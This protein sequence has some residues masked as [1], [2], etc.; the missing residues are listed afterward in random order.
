[1]IRDSNRR[2][3][4]LPW[5]VLLALAAT[6]ATQANGDSPAALPEPPEHPEALGAGVGRAMHLLSSSTAEHRNKVRILFYGQSI[7]EQEWWRQVVANLRQRFPHADLEV[8]NRAIGGFPSQQLVKPAEH[9]I[10]AFYPDLVI[11]HV[12]GSDKTYAEII[13]SIRSRTTAEVLMQTDHITKWPPATISKSQDGGA[14]WDDRMNRKIL[15]GIAAKYGCGLVDIHSDWLQHL[16]TNHLEPAAL[17]LDEVHLNAAGCDLMARLVE[18]YLV[19]QLGPSDASWARPVRTEPI[20]RDLVFT[21]GKLTTQFQGNRVDLVAGRL[22]EPARTLTVRVDGKKPSEFPELYAI[23]RPKPKPW[24]EIALIRVNHDKPLVAEDW[25]LTVDSYAEKPPSWTFHVQG[26]QTGPDGAGSSGATFVSPSGRVHIEPDFWFP[27]KPVEPGYAIHWS[28]RPQFVDVYTPPPLGDSTL[29]RATTLVQGLSNGPHTL[30]LIAGP[31][32]PPELAAIR[33]Y[34][35]PYTPMNPLVLG[36]L[37]AVGVLVVG[38]VGWRLLRR[39]GAG[40]TAWSRL[41]RGMA[42]PRVRTF[43]EG[44]ASP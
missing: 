12:Y 9:D 21:G 27:Q 25:T 41:T 28:V 34:E 11:F 17:L 6:A 26:S 14:W 24:S 33:I 32:G 36:G 43:S 38:W 18:R 29:D 7:T 42:R 31:D 19:V 16:K 13:R 22:N 5:V 23:T 30:E 37:V 20:G 3:W 8:E 44:S 15:P 4:S 39:S 2:R 35:P 10:F 40:Q 1:L